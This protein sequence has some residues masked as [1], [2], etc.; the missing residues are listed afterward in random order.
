MTRVLERHAQA[1]LVLGA[2]SRLAA[3]LDLAAL[4]N[5][6]LEAANILIVN[7]ANLI[8]TKRADLSPGTEVASPAAEATA[9]HWAVATLASFSAFPAATLAMFTGRRCRSVR[10]A[11][12]CRVTPLHE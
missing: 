10:C 3:W 6:P 9:S 12:N 7:L 5:I 2:C 4:R 8:N 11:A 1:T